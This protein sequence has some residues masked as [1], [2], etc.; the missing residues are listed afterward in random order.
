M[1]IKEAL[2]TTTTLCEL[3]DSFW[4]LI[5]DWMKKREPFCDCD[6]LKKIPLGSFM[7]SI[8]SRNIN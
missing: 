7:G 4:Q 8:V 2:T 1:K 3:T 5:S 6:W